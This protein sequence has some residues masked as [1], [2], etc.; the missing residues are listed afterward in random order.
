MFVLALVTFMMSCAG[1][2]HSPLMT[3]YIYQMYTESVYGNASVGVEV[4]DKSADLYM[5][6]DLVSGGIAIVTNLFL[7]AYSDVL[8]RRFVL[9]VPVLGPKFPYFNLHLLIVVET[10]ILLGFYVYAADITRGDKQRTLG[11]AIVEA[12]IGLADAATEFAAGLIIED[13]GFLYVSLLASGLLLVCLVIILCGLPETVPRDRKRLISPLEGVKRM[14]KVF[15][16]RDHPY[17]AALLLLGLLAFFMVDFPAYS[18]SKL[19]W[20]SSQVMVEPTE[21]SEAGTILLCMMMEMRM[22]MALMP[23][24]QATLSITRGMVNFL[25]A[26]VY[27]SIN[28][29]YL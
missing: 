6:L 18:T 19:Q 22:I 17:Q 1:K 24:Y 29:I 16:A 10:G 8:G 4:Q 2:F 27:L 20:C 13:T 26:G 14:C 3:Q 9:L 5:R 21:D 23:V 15:V 11:M 7:G 28:I 12:G 25:V